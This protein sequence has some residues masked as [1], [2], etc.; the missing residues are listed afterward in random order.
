MTVR[1]V[2]MLVRNEEYIYHIIVFSL[3]RSHSNREKRGEGRLV[4]VQAEIHSR[5]AFPMPFY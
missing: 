3:Y 2:R 1:T 4:V 5:S